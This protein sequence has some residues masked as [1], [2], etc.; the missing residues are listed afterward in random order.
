MNNNLF[1]KVILFVLI[2][3]LS[4]NIIIFTPLFL[5]LNNK[6]SKLINNFYWN[7]WKDYIIWDYNWT[8][9]VCDK[10]ESF[11]IHG[12]I[13]A[14]KLDIDSRAYLL[15]ELFSFT[16]TDNLWSIS[17]YWYSLFFYKNNS[18][19]KSNFVD[20]YEDIPKYWYLS[21]SD[22]K[23]Y[24]ENDLKNLTKEQQTIFKELE[25]N[26]KIVTDWITYKW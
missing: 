9:R 6:K 15:L 11:C 17:Q 1:L 23:F 8:T 26:P 2:I 21:W 7:I 13:K 16:T 25:K 24:S 4:F 5:D 20:K 19:Y 10:E 22:L 12:D 3:I 18:K 14:L